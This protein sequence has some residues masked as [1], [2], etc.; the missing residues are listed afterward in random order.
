[1]VELLKSSRRML[2][3]AMD[4]VKTGEQ[5]LQSKLDP[6]AVTLV[7]WRPSMQPDRYSCGA[8]SCFMILRYFG[9]ARSVENHVCNIY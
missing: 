6:G 8:Q 2:K 3:S 4:L 5:R 1:M 7:G 9:K